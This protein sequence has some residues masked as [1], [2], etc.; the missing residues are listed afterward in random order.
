M[1]KSR[2]IHYT[3]IPTELKII[4][5]KNEPLNYANVQLGKPRG[6]WVSVEDGDGWKEWCLD[7]DFYLKNLTYKYE[8][9][10]KK[11]MNILYL[12]NSNEI[13]SFTDEYGY[14][15]LVEIYEQLNKKY[16]DKFDYSF[17]SCSAV[18]WDLLYE[19]YQGI[20]IAP[21]CWKRRLD[22]NCQWYYGW[23]C[24]SGCIWDI[25]AIEKFKLICDKPVVK[26]V[27]L[28]ET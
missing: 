15:P 1:N 7:N 12:K 5:Y 23:D 11:D 16:P 25:S 18:R 22:F 13:L 27:E 3:S 17:N 21:Y 6:L 19:K 4:D 14:D 2:L 26:E 24:S 10:L 9:V 28:I 20:V 8:V